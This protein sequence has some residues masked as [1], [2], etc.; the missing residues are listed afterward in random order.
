MAPLA[1]TNVEFPE[2][3]AALGTITVGVVVT[4]TVVFAELVQ[5]PM[6]PITVYVVV[7]FGFKFCEAPA[8]DPGF[9]I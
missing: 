4:L 3:M 1:V 9:Q 8:R 5:E 2:Q 6:L 7:E